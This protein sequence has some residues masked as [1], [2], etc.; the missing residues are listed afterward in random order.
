MS[1]AN[2]FLLLLSAMALP[3]ISASLFADEP[4]SKS[5][6]D[7][8]TFSF[9]MEND[10]FGDTDQQYT[11][12]I[13]IGWQSP[14]LAYYAQ[15]ERLPAWIHRTMGYLPW[16]HHPDSQKNIGITLGQKIFTPEDLEAF[17][18]IID[19]R[20]YAGWL[21]ACLLYTSP[22]PRDPE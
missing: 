6:S 13:Q 20:P 9:F 18:L 17:D 19:D 1:L 14:D 16:I 12:G 3:L 4:V 22:S 15:E 7:S 8:S 11:N 10:L 21:Y 5:P 2:R